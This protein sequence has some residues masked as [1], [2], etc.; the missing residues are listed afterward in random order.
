MCVACVQH[1]AAIYTSPLV[2]PLAGASGGKEKFA[3]GG[4]RWSG[5]HR[6][7]ASLACRAAGPMSITRWKR[8]Q[9]AVAQRDPHPPSPRDACLVFVHP[10]PCVSASTQRRRRMM[11]LQPTAV[12]AWIP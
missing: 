4:E 3:V 7:K 11:L 8:A 9:P 2:R 6:A 5:R 1:H 12:P 10:L